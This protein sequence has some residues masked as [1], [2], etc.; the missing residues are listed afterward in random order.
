M[1]FKCLSFR[2]L[3]ELFQS[4]LSDLDNNNDSEITGHFN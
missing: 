2:E 1:G 3:K 4:L